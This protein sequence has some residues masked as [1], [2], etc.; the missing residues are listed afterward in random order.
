MDKVGPCVNSIFRGLNYRN[1]WQFLE[2]LE[3]WNQLFVPVATFFGV[4]FEKSEFAP[5]RKLT[6]VRIEGED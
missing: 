1:F 6:A 4:N 3:I 2:D 5:L